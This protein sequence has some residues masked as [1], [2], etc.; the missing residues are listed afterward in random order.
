MV[1]F[2][3]NIAKAYPPEAGIDFW[4]RTFRFDRL[5][6]RIEIADAYSLNKPANRITLTLMSASKPVEEGGGR[7]RLGGNTGIRF[8]AGALKPSIEEIPLEDS[9]LR[10][11]WGERIWRIL[12][13]AERPPREGRFTLLISQS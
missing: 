2:R 3:L 13:V 4:R 8:E 7:L 9:R 11:T 6:N 1:E 5:E 12:L 10:G